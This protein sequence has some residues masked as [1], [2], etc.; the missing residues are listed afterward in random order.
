MNRSAL[1][2]FGSLMLLATMLLP[3]GAAPAQA[4]IVLSKVIVDL[5]GD[6]PP[7]DDIEVFNDSDERQYVVAEPA[8]IQAPGTPAEKRV[9]SA[10]PSVTGL[11][12]TPQKLVLEPHQRKLIRVAVIAPRGADER[13]YRLAI[14]PVAGSVLAE[15]TA[16]K[17]FLGYDALIIVR[18]MVA[19]GK[20]TGKRTANALTLHNGSN[21]SVEL[22]QGRQC[23]GSGKGCRPLPAMRL[24]AG[25]DWTVPITLDTPVS[26]TVQ[27]G[28]V[29]TIETF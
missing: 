7:R 12:V 24:Y 11:L 8:L 23:D 17:V 26:Y 4:G 10:D 1:P 9:D 20:V 25:A 19:T 22:S 29:S 3:L 5:P 13:V 27:R 28:K 21:A 18:P 2:R 16:L 15:G 6:G 14:K